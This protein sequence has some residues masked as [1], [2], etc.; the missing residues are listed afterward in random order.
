[1]ATSAQVVAQKQ[2]SATP[3]TWALWVP[4]I[5]DNQE[6]QRG[7]QRTATATMDRGSQPRG[8]GR[9]VQRCMGWAPL[10]IMWRMLA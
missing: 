2:W 7:R 1:M 5:P 6:Y 3:E 10:R 9:W 4:R 8:P